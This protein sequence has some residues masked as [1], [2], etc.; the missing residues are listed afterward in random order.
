MSYRILDVAT[1]TAVGAVVW[2]GGSAG[3]DPVVFTAPPPVPVDSF[4]HLGRVSDP[5]LPDLP[6]KVEIRQLPPDDAEE[7]ELFHP[8]PVRFKIVLGSP[9][10]YVPGADLEFSGVDRRDA[11]DHLRD[12]ILGLCDDLFDEDPAT[13]GPR[14]TAQLK[15]LEKH[16]RRRG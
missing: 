7:F 11:L 10:A 2:L 15:V 13:L 14:P 16:L 9:V 3:D 5:R 4:P 1:A 12:W 8:I 6:R